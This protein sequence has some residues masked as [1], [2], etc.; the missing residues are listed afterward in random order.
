[1]SVINLEFFEQAYELIYNKYSKYYR[2]K[3]NA[4]HKIISEIEN[5]EARTVGIL[6]LDKN[7][8][9]R[10]FGGKGKQT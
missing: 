5:G 4:K 1:M 6:N 9:I 7:L 3:E 2:I 10:L 8:V